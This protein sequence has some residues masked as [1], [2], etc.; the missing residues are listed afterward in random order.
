MLMQ[1][2]S[3]KFNT[4]LSCNT[5]LWYA[6]A[7]LLLSVK[8]I[9]KGTTSKWRMETTRSNI[10]KFGE[11]KLFEVISSKKFVQLINLFTQIDS[12]HDYVLFSTKSQKKQTHSTNVL[13]KTNRLGHSFTSQIYNL[14]FLNLLNHKPQL[15]NLYSTKCITFLLPFQSFNK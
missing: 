11:L 1:I 14:F 5:H 6:I 10:I 15:L 8:L 3:T 12:Y 2:R 9:L 13:N 4:Y 7:F